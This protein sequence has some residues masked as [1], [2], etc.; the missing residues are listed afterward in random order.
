MAEQF[1]L[2]TLARTQ[3]ARHTLRGD[4]LAIDTVDDFLDI[5]GRK[6]P[7]DGS[8]RRLN[9]VTLAAK[10]AGDAPADLKS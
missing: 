10:F 9:R 6:R 8:P 5:E 7:I 4:I 3:P 2:A 1:D